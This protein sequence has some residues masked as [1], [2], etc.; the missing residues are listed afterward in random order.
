MTIEGQRLRLDPLAHTDKDAS[1]LNL[2]D[3]FQLAATAT[4]AA[5]PWPDHVVYQFPTGM[6]PVPGARVE[7]VT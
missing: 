7:V 1:F 4:P 3:G 2:F 6:K 5:S